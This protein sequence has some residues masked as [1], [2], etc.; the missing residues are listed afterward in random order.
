LPA[1]SGA[2]AA[3]IIAQA[4]ASGLTINCRDVPKIA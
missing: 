1:A 4:A 2:T 3:A